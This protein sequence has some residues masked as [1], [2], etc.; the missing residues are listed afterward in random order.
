MAGI[1]LQELLQRMMHLYHGGHDD[2]G[3]E[4]EEEPEAPAALQPIMR[5]ILVNPSV[6]KYLPGI[7]CVICAEPIFNPVQTP[8]HHTFCQRY[9]S[10]TTFCLKSIFACFNT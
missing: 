3:G 2:D 6:T 7:E 10:Y 8:C 9:V 1:N 4:E 5:T